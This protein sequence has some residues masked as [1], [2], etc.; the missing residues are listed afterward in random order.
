MKIIEFNSDKCKH[1][2]KCVRSC[3]VKAIS[4]KNERAEII[5]LHCILCGQCL[6]VCPQSAKT[7]YS[8]LDYV[9]SMIA[10]GEKVV[11]TMAPSYMGLL[12]YKTLGQ[13]KAAMKKL[14]FY[15]VAETSEGA[16]VV[17]AEY[18]RLIREGKMRNIIT[19]CC[20]SV[21]YLIEMYHPSLV[22][23]LAPVVSPM[24]ASG[25]LIRRRIPDCKVVFVGPCIA[26]KREAREGAVNKRVINA[27][28]TF[29]DLKKWLDEEHIDIGACEDEPFEL[30]PRVNRLYPV[31]GG[32]LKSV[33]ATLAQGVGSDIRVSQD[34][35]GTWDARQGDGTWKHYRK[36]YVHG[37]KDCNE[38]CRDMEAGGVNGCFIE[39]N[40]CADGCIK[41]PT[42]NDNDVYKYKVKLDMGERIPKDAPSEKDIR[43]LMGDLDFHKEFHGCDLG[44]PEP[45]E[46]QIRDILAKTGKYTAEDELNCGACGYATC[47]DKA[48]AVFQGKAELDMCI[49]YMHMQAESMA[50]IVMQESPNAVIM[51]D[52][53]LTILE[54]SRVGQKYFGIPRSKALKMKL[55]DIFDPSLVEQ[56]FRTQKAVHGRKVALPKYKLM[57]LQ[58]IVF[59]PKQDDVLITIS[60]ITPQENMLRQEYDNRRHYMGLAQEVIR[61]QMITAQQIASLLG[62]TTA[63]T[64]ST[65]SMLVDSIRAEDME[66]GMPVE[67]AGGDMQAE[68]TGNGLPSGSA[69]KFSSGAAI[70]CGTESKEDAKV[71]AS[72]KAEAPGENAAA[73]GNVSTGDSPAGSADDDLGIPVVKPKKQFKIV[74]TYAA[75]KEKCS[76]TVDPETG[77]P[78]VTGMADTVFPDNKRNPSNPVKKF[79][80]NDTYSRKKDE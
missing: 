7:L 8:E 32:I 6:R 38:L 25:M 29:E 4:V 80:I 53:S 5:G 74:E 15:D 67:E 26:K 57:T 63:E 69:E 23:Y 14:G 79:K 56:V 64:K 55:G 2:Y 20:P 41:G 1:C 30:D 13:V 48:I 3:E 21:N 68:E 11:L 51:V 77:L 45:T 44:D 40:M 66:N 62:E 22:K 43:T 52:R 12:K 47:R 78:I 59:I 34:P 27:V 24:I 49:P 39:M 17:T 58:N 37:A 75:P 65:L 70:Y 46:E 73:D 36:F 28:I 60:D 33:R 71:P 50:N 54:Y 31:T 35:D 42:V 76:E 16:A 10:S 72:D 19:T 9:K 18:A 61:K